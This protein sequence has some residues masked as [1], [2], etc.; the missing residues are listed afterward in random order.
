MPFSLNTYS[1]QGF[2]KE[3]KVNAT[4]LKVYFGI[5]GGP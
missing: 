3:S 1:I 2:L 4:L 5:F